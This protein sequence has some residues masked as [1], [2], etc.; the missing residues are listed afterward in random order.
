MNPILLDM[1]PHFKEPKALAALERGPVAPATQVKVFKPK[2]IG[3]AGKAR[4]GKD[5]VAKLLQKY[6]AINTISFAEPIRDALRGM[7]GLNDDHFHGSLKEVSLGWI[8]KSP[9]QLM[10]TLGTQWG[11]E[12]VDQD[13]WLKLAK[14]NIEASHRLGIHVVIT[15]VRFDNEAEFIR[16]N[17]GIVWHISRG[18]APQVNT[19]ASE[20]GVTQAPG[21]LYVDNNG[22]LE[23]LESLVLTLF[24]ISGGYYEH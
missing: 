10:Q 2:L 13:I 1:F 6:N 18:D 11:R 3:L 12:L 8:D 9:R 15:D 17:G 23:E 21:D 19:H 5:T 20:A 22:T 7:I 24:N 4:S 14:R 16:D